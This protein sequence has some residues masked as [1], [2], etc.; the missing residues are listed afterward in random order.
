MKLISQ[1]AV[2]SV[3]VSQQEQSLRF[4]VD[5]LGLVKQ[6]DLCLG[7]DM[8]LL[9]VSVRDQLRPE[10][11][12]AR[13][14]VAFHG[15]QRIKDVLAYHAQHVAVAFVTENLYEEY[16]ALR[17]RGVTFTGMP[18]QREYGLSTTFIDPDGNAFLLL[19]ST[20]AL[21]HSFM[22]RHFGTAA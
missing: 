22:G 3:P 11:A 15:E 16:K 20:P 19:E 18:V 2:I 10:L 6:R 14:D 8:R 4:Y 21:Q 17:G 5:V 1:H 7:P 12:L 9:T 13:V